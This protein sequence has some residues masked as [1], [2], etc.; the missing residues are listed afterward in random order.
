MVALV[1]ILPF[2]LQL[3]VTLIHIFQM[4]YSAMALYGLA[5]HPGLRWSVMKVKFNASQPSGPELCPE[6]T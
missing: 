6:I 4:C 1:S 5:A 2:P 3:K